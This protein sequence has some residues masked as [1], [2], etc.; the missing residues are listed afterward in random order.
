NID[1]RV[2]AEVRTGGYGDD[3]IGADLGGCSCGGGFGEGEGVA[4]HC[5]SCGGGEGWVSGAVDAGGVGGGYSERGLSYGESAVVIDDRVVAEVRAGG[6]GD[7][8][9]GSDW[10]RRSCGSGF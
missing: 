6:Y 2:V 4:V 9:I 8:R 3:R 1:D 10:R 5:A 7:D